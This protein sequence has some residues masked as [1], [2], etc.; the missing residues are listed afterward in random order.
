MFTNP[1]VELAGEDA[2]GDAERVDERAAD[3]EHGHER[4]PA[5]REV[6]QRRPQAVLNEYVEAWDHAAQAKRDE[7]AW[8]V[9]YNHFKSHIRVLCYA[10]R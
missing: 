2:L 5:E 9:T 3:V 6:V 4:E 1:D 10:L 7:D 8:T